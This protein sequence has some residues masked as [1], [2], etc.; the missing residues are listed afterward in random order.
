M[1]WNLVAKDT[2]CSSSWDGT[3][4]VVRNTFLLKPNPPPRN[5]PL[6]P[7]T[8]E[9]NPP[10]I[11]PHPPHPLLHLLR[12]LLPTLPHPPLHR[13]LRLPPP[14]LRPSHSTLSLQPPRPHN[15]NPFRPK[16]LSHQP[17]TPRRQWLNRSL[18]PQ[19]SPNPRLEQ[20]PL[21]HPRNRRRRPPNPHL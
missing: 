17:T 6:T 20:I 10:T 13:I 18:S 3:V 9:P 11:P 14:P 4:K 1:H 5:T 21:H 19:R 16:P 12:R 8:V 2:F 7:T 15:P